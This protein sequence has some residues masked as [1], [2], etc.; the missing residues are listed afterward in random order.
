MTGDESTPLPFDHVLMGQWRIEDV[1]GQND[2]FVTYEAVHDL[3]RQ[4]VVIKEYFPAG[5][6][7]RDDVDVQP[8]E[9]EN[10]PVL[11]RG[12]QRF[13]AESQALA[14]LRNDYLVRQFN[15]FEENGTAYCVTEFLRGDNLSAKAA[16]G[17]CDQQWLDALVDAACQGLAAIHE[18]YCLHL[19]VTPDRILFPSG[20]AH[21][22]LLCVG[23]V[24]QNSS[25][26]G[27]DGEMPPRFASP[28]Y[29]SPE[30]QVPQ[31]GDPG[32]WSD[33]YSLAAVLY[34]C[35]TGQPPPA[36]AARLEQMQADPYAEVCTKELMAQ[37]YRENFL[38]GID[39]ALRL[40]PSDR[41]QDL[42]AWQRSLTAGPTAATDAGEA[43]EL[44]G[45]PVAEAA[46]GQIRIETIPAKVADLHLYLDDK[47]I[48][49]GE[50]FPVGVHDLQVTARGFETLARRVQI[51]ETG[52]RLQVSLQRS[53]DHL[54]NEQLIEAA[55]N[56]DAGLLTA[57]LESGADPDA[58]DADGQTALM[59]A[60]EQDS[61]DVLFLLIQA[62]ADLD[63]QDS[64]GRTALMIACRRGLVDLAYVLLRAE[65]ALDLQDKQGRTALSM[66]TS[67]KASEAVEALLEVGAA[68]AIADAS[69]RTP[70]MIATD[71]ADVRVVQTLL[72]AQPNPDAQDQ[73]GRTALMIAASRGAAECVRAL[74]AEGAST[75]LLTTTGKSALD[76]AIAMGDTE[77][78]L[79]LGV[80]KELLAAADLGQLDRV[81]ALLDAGIDVDFCNPDGR[82]AL[83][84]ATEGSHAEVVRYLVE[85][86]AAQTLRDANGQ[87]ALDHAISGKNVEI[88]RLL[89][90]D[91]EVF[92]AAEAGEPD[93]IT[94]CMAAGVS[95]EYQDELGRTAITI[96]IQGGQ[97]EV[98]QAL[99]EGGGAVNARIGEDGVTALEMACEQGWVDAVRL[100]LSAGADTHLRNSK[101]GSALLQAVCNGG[102]EIVLLLLAADMPPDYG[103]TT[104]GRTALMVACEQGHLRLVR[105][106][107][108]AGADL[109]ITDN[110]GRTA[111]WYGCLAER[112]EI[113][114]LLLATNLNVNARQADGRTALAAMADMGA[115]ERVK[116]LLQANADVNTEDA[117]G[118]TPLHYACHTGQVELVRVLLR[119]KAKVNT[120][121]KEGQT[122][123]I[124]AVQAGA[125][126]IVELLLKAKAK[127]ALTDKAGWT[128][129][130]VASRMG[131]VQIARMLLLT[132]SAGPFKKAH[133]GRSAYDIALEAGHEILAESLLWS[134]TLLF[135]RPLLR[136]RFGAWLVR[137][138]SPDRIHPFLFGE[139]S[140]G[141]GGATDAPASTETRIWLQV[142]P[143]KHW[144][145][146]D[147]APFYSGD[148]ASVG[149]HELR[150][151]ARGYAPEVVP[152][153]THGASMNL[154]ISL[155]KP[156]EGQSF[157]DLQE[158]PEVVV[159]PVKG[160]M[161]GTDPQTEACET[162]ETPRHR[163]RIGYR[164]ALGKY[165]V[166]V[167]QYAAFFAATG[168]DS[169]G[170]MR[171]YE[172]GK[173]DYRAD[174]SWR[175]PGFEQHGNHPVV[176]VSWE[177]AQAYVRWLSSETGCTYRLPS[178]AEWE[179][180]ARAGSAS[181]YHTGATITAEQAH[182]RG[183]QQSTMEVGTF[184]GNAFGLHDVHG[185]VD[186]WVEDCWNPNYEGAPQDGDPW[187]SGDCTRRV[188]R[189][190]SWVYGSQ[191]ARVALRMR[192][193]AN[194][195]RNNL[196]FRVAR[197]IEQGDLEVERTG[198]R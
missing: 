141:E 21:P 41:P 28:G 189:G 43:G 44:A 55:R 124:G 110:E 99:L 107:L 183:G 34:F 177:D 52:L 6:A 59:I 178:E 87:T 12:C 142:A 8:K 145:S 147:G 69:G 185:N 17:T 73:E 133:D 192:A 135:L 191:H 180:A 23:I 198:Y 90:A 160:F 61:V 148:W 81:R 151:E 57:L 19:D 42:F 102:E 113:L 15:S 130:M 118:R 36:A 170:N 115:T 37:G 121:D 195:K 119:A 100:L 60:S 175:S 140:D 146:L 89:G 33:I 186:E 54:A 16:A 126:A 181:P 88:L 40:Q 38:R 168:H 82:T 112:P 104:D 85:K 65:A 27:E 106:L 96:A 129:L 174:R 4:R 5:I 164:I 1:L 155:Q 14:A 77:T 10:G 184:P 97:M 67:S 143:R 94:A 72:Q 136:W 171:T 157:R 166:T 156:R 167:A 120:Q 46:M 25:A 122:V 196:G 108:Q 169:T 152:I 45:Q 63:K 93:R 150:V 32:T 24:E 29:A 70:L 125:A 153:R 47:Q 103:T 194:T 139:K 64:E 91:K 3:S 84:A 71:G 176:Y 193:V 20:G 74:L 66:A 78:A 131:N 62:G 197:L 11:T 172:D 162:S 7:V 173:W 132:T 53:M 105:H 158:S 190:G 123:L 50:V 154:E 75:E 165:P 163:V 116:A 95:A 83:M 30:L 35:I 149:E 134:V 109:E 79:L 188:H 22:M 98:L 18:R 13:I 161:M 51:P 48:E 68:S 26:A 138:T 9:Q 56:H 58:T 144:L 182:L 137:A 179:Y 187:L 101:G 128:A 159:L 111:L 2:T 114:P 92:R 117:S 49:N 127:P 39:A 86:G 76:H 31:S 80:G